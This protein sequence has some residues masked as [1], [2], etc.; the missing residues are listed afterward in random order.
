M[1]FVSA[2]DRAVGAGRAGV[3]CAPLRFLLSK[4]S[5]KKYPIFS[6]S[7]KGEARDSNYEKSIEEIALKGNCT[8]HFEKDETIISAALVS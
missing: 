7:I 4:T 8:V 5:N 2:M 3:Q 6:T 1:S